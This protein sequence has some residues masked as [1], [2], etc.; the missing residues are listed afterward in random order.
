MSTRTSFAATWQFTYLDATTQ[1]RLLARGHVDQSTPHPMQ[2]LFLRIIRVRVDGSGGARQE[3]G[4]RDSAGTGSGRNVGSSGGGDPQ[5]LWWQ[6][7]SGGGASNRAC[8]HRRGR[9]APLHSAAQGQR[10]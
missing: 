5:R 1:E 6:R 9:D 2:A 7:S 3:L 4:R 8:S 10:R